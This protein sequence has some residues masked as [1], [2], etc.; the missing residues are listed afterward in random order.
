MIPDISSGGIEVTCQIRFRD[1]EGPSTTQLKN[2][3]YSTCSCHTHLALPCFRSGEG[4]TSRTPQGILDFSSLYT[5]RRKHVGGT[6]G[7]VIFISKSPA[8]A[9][10]VPAV[11]A[12]LP[13]LVCGPH[14]SRHEADA[15]AAHAYA[16]DSDGNLRHALLRGPSL[17][18]PYASAHP[19]IHGIRLQGMARR[20]HRG[21]RATLF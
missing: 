7:T 6:N 5:R 8:A 3:P 18:T 19:S 12:C 17:Y 14:G 11:S 20:P 13:V 21:R 9:T 2:Q 10:P 1:L 16:D 15:R 4:V